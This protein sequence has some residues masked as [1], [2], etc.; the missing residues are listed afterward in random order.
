M[1]GTVYGYMA[2]Y[3]FAACCKPK[4]SVRY[5]GRMRIHM[6]LE[7]HEPAFTPE[8]QIAIDAAVW[9]VT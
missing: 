8:Q 7:A 5:V 4:P 3:T 9:G 1:I 2:A 6:A